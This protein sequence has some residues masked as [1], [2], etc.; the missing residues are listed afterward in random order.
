MRRKSLIDKKKVIIAVGALSIGM[1]GIIACSTFNEY[2][3][4]IRQAHKNEFVERTALW[5]LSKNMTAKE[6][7]SR[8]TTV[9]KGDSVLICKISRIPIGA[10]SD[11]M[12]ETAKPTR[13]AWVRIR[14]AHMESLISGVD[15]MEKRAMEMPFSSYVL[16]SKS[17]Y[18]ELG[19]SR[20]SFLNEKVGRE[21]E[22]DELYPQKVYSEEAFKNWEGRYKSLFSS[23]RSGGKMIISYNPSYFQE[24]TLLSHNP[25]IV[26]PF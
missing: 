25:G 1:A 22:L 12:Q 18:D 15:W 6:M 3:C 26:I 10:Y 17:K 16:C 7:L 14:E 11:F 23:T 9:A 13:R 24:K 8:M 5:N 21:K 20:P 4:L 2:L 19:N